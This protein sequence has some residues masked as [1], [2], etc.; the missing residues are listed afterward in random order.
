M[1]AYFYFTLLLLA[2]LVFACKDGGDDTD[3]ISDEY[4]PDDL[5]GKVVYQ[6]LPER[7]I[8]MA[9]INSLSNA[10]SYG[11]IMVSTQPVWSNDGTKF[12]AIE[13]QS[14]VEP[15]TVISD[16]VIKIVDVESESTTIMKIGSSLH[17]DLRGPLSWSPDG[18]TL[19]CVAEA[20][21][22]II[23]LDTETGDTIQTDF[24]EQTYG[25]I[26]S[27]DWHP[28]G[29]IAVS[30][31]AWH[32]Y[33]HDIE[34]CLL[35]PLTTTLKTQLSAAT[36]TLAFPFKFMDWNAAG[37][38]LLLSHDVYHSEIYVL[39]FNTGEFSIIP[40]IYGMAPCWSP[41]GKYIMYTGVSGLDG[42]TIIPG[43]F[44]TDIEGSFE[45]LLITDAA[46][47]DWY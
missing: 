29:D 40:N 23:Y 35:E 12:A 25:W 44:M 33:Q 47:S 46:Y 20:F 8:K 30:I 28:D 26:T 5:S 32:D 13:L 15:D 36:I 45:T 17:N 10:T 37:S 19:A 24:A 16:F 39:D 38:K 31:N 42:S 3:D 27:L 18:K 11:D 14:S 6:K 4:V 9:D 22:R 7:T 2:F 1:K 41:D 34:I 43:L 21:S